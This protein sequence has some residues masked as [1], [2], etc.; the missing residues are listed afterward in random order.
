[1][2]YRELAVLLPCHSLEDFP[3]Y[4]TGRDA[5]S[6]LACW[7]ALWHPAL[8]VAVDSPPK[9][10][11]VDYPPDDL[12]EKLLLIPTISVGQ[13]P[14]DFSDRAKEAK[15]LVITGESDRGAI[16]AQALQ[17]LDGRGG[18]IDPELV[19]DFPGAGLRVSSSASAYASDALLEQFERSAVL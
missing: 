12:Q 16:L 13:L 1:M 7:T 5:E 8:L 11:R 4:H 19:A 9:W 15:A 2:K 17:W 18:N 6:L 10:H 14:Y 3:L